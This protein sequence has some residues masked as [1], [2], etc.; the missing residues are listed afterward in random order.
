MEFAGFMVLTTAIQLAALRPAGSQVETIPT[1]AAQYHWENCLRA[2]GHLAL[3]YSPA[4]AFSPDGSIL[5]VVS[6]DKIALTN[7]RTRTISKVLRI[8][9]QGISD[10][11]IQSANSLPN[12]NLFVLAN[13]L[14]KTKGHSVI[15]RSP[16]LAFQWNPMKDELSGKVDAVG[17]GGGFLP[18][19]YF[20]AFHAVCLYKDSHFI[21]W[22]PTMGK[23]AGFILPQLT[24]PPHYFQFSPDFHWLILAQV[25]MNAS[26]NP[27]VV[28]MHDHQFVNVLPGHHAVV[29][30]AR[31]SRDGKKLVTTCEDGA[32]RVWSVPDWKLLETLT[33]HAGPVH[34]AEF[35]PDGRWI[36]SAGEDK[37]VRIWSAE[38]GKLLQVLRESPDPLLTLAF[39]P[40]G[41]YLAGT[42]EKTVMVWSL[43]K[44]D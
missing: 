31:F 14:L 23:S 3:R 24:H 7:L 33:G 37:T 5:A 43:E 35:S 39:S 38:D 8:H 11:D 19:R 21:L 44:T 18:V 27:I 1:A 25:E 6:K 42:S 15:L 41:R 13:G 2:E 12:G 4:G 32:V 17:Q 28:Q 29:L 36:A 26:A 40:D 16:E 22:D 9:L 34:W 30:S 10:I 20:P